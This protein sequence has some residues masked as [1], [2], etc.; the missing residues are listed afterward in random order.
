LIRMKWLAFVLLLLPVG[1]AAQTPTQG[2]ITVSP[3]ISNTNTPI[4]RSRS[5]SSAAGGQATGGQGGQ[6]GLGGMGGQ[7]SSSANPSA[8]PVASSGSASSTIGIQTG[9]TTTNIPSDTIVRAAPLLYVPSVSTG[10][11]CALGASAG[12]SW[13]AAAV[14]FGASWESMQC[15]RRQAAALLWNMGTPES[16]AAAKEVICNTQEIRDAYKR[17]GAPCAADM[18]YV[19]GVGAQQRAA[20]QEVLPPIVTFDPTP[21]ARASDCLMAAQRAGAPLAVCAGKR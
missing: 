12:A 19:A 20:P 8:N 14:A 18:M 3:P 17:I 5:T 11:V 6:G 1:V 13:I 10:N 16:K 21:Y 2:A 4:S 9:N 7:S 15:E